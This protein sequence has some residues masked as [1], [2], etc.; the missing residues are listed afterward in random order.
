MGVV[1]VPFFFWGKWLI[2]GGLRVR[3]EL[4]CLTRDLLGNLRLGASRWG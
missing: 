2:A 4:F 3:R 1:I